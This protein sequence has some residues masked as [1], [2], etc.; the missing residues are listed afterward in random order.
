MQKFGLQQ[1]SMKERQ[2]LM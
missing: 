2:R 1:E